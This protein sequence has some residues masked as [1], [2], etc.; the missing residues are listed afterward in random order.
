M[1]A[2]PL[3]HEATSTGP[4]SS[5]TRSAS[6]ASAGRWAT[7]TAVRPP[8]GG[9]RPRARRPPSRRRG[10]PS[11]RPE[12]AAERL[13]RRPGRARR[14]GAR[15][16]RVPPLLAE[17]GVRR[18][19]GAGV[20]PRS[21]R[22]PRG[23]RHIGV[24]GVGTAEPDVVGHRAGEEVWSLGHPADVAAPVVEVEVGEVHA[25]ERYRSRR[26]AAA[27]RGRPPAGSTCRNRWSRSRPP[28]P[29]GERQA[30]P[31]RVRETPRP[32]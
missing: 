21:V 32:G 5:T 27:S 8:P 25:A 3:A 7:I 20:R 26:R 23:P 31:R 4:G 18:R 22:R 10:W 30:P 15:R 2:R 17:Q 29:R 12:G 19:G 6:A 13:G 9:A 28:S 11:A 14:A 16:P 24:R 1:P